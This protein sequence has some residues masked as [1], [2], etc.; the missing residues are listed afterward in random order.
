MEVMKKTKIVCTI[1][2]ASESEEIL[3]KLVQEGMNVARLNFS[4]G[5]HEEHR[6]KIET[7]RRVRAKM[8]VPLAIA[9]DTKGPEI[10]LGTFVE[11]PVQIRRGDKLTLTTRDVPGT[12][13]IVHISYAGLPQDVVTGTRILIDDGLVEFVVERVDNGTDIVCVAQ[14]FGE[15]SDR[16]GVNVPSTNIK[17]PAITESDL[18]DIL[19]G[20]D[21]GVDFIFASFIRTAE[22][23]LHIRKILEENGG[24]DIHIYAKIESAQGVANLDEIL[25]AVD[26]LMVARGDLGV[27]IPTQE[28][29]L[30]QKEIIRK[31]NLAGKPV[32]TATQM[33]DSMTRNPR[34]TRAEVND[35][36]NAILDGSDAIMLSG[37]T[38][39]G[40]YP[41][42][43]VRQMNMIARTTEASVD[44]RKSVANRETW[45]ER[46]TSSA[47]ALSTC[48]IAAALE[49]KAI[50]TATASGYTS[51]QISKFRPA[52]TIIAA[53]PREDVARKLSICWGVCPVL[54]VDSE[55]TD[56][57]I[58]R[59]IYAAMQ[60]GYVSEGDQIVLTAGIPVGQGQSTNMIKVHTIGDILLVGTGLGRQSIAGKVC[61]GS[62]AEELQPI[63]EDG[64][65]LVASYTDADLVNY[66][67]R[68]SGLIVEEGG[69]T[70]HAA[71]VALHYNKPAIIGAEKATQMLKQGDLVTIDAISGLVYAGKAQ[72]I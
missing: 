41:V 48:R 11:G 14:N 4:H 37:E 8:G 46:E 62:T 56:E 66:I 55:H 3:T 63:F 6:K 33:L 39:A 59:S 2:P 31:S 20:I 38:A 23:V 9:L 34:P 13:A 70:S 26:G 12:K 32:I 15:I 29:P 61:I 68:A 27:E 53:T 67:E 54:S 51:R 64:D 21:M 69:L 30:V 22:D 18:S 44:F 49:T 7:L 10:R 43:A 42:Q 25:E 5:T 17:L 40:K 36:A 47:I 28:V 60:T 65:I 19:F 52:A 24:S 57:L 1:G 50:V 71:V 35:V 45:M 58:E 16:K 72:V